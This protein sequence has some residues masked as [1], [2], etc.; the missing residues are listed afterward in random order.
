MRSFVKENKHLCNA[1]LCFGQEHRGGEGTSLY[2]RLSR[3]RH[4]LTEQAG[5]SYQLGAFPNSL[6]HYIPW[7]VSMGISPVSLCSLR[8]RFPLLYLNVLQ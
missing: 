3:L 7:S 8:K 2:F 6:E 1:V 5:H 4:H